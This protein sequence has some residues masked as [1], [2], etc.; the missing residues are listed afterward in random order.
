MLAVWQNWEAA[1]WF[2]G[3]VL[4][5]GLLGHFLVFRI[6]QGLIK[7]TK[8]VLDDSLF[9]HCYRPLQWCVILIVIHFAVATFNMPANFEAGAKRL[10]ALLVI[11]LVA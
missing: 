10:I 2:L 11:A 8:N 3:A 5:V 1:A 7:R 6:V 9:R 4:M